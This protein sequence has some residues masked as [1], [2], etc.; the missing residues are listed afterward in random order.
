MLRSSNVGSKN[1]GGYLT[2]FVETLRRNESFASKADMPKQCFTSQQIIFFDTL[3]FVSDYQ[4]KMQEQERLSNLAFPDT[5]KDEM[6]QWKSDSWP[7]LLGGWRRYHA[8][9]VVNEEK[10][11]QQTVVVIGG[12]KAEL[13][14]TNS[15]LMMDLEKDTK[16]WREGPSLNQNRAF[17]AAVVCN[18]SVYAMGGGC[19]GER[20]DS[21]ERIDL[22]DL[23]KS[24]CATNNKT[25]WKK[26]TCTLSTPRGGCQA[27]AVNNRF[28]VIV[29]GYNGSFLSSTDILDTAVKTQHIV[30]PGPSLTIPRSSCGMAVVGNRIIAIG[31]SNGSSDHLNSVEYLDFIDASKEANHRNG[32]CTRIWSFL[33][34]ERNMLLGKSGPH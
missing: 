21:I 25:H 2:R 15:V 8:S 22:L 18:G 33:S 28:I 30:T 1:V 34:L 16:Q 20:L 29:G 31:G 14:V 32:K 4:R 23:W 13:L 6:P 26:L 27:A 3:S 12:Q 10:K 7:P 9:V 19:D 5:N 17:H 11:G 24:P